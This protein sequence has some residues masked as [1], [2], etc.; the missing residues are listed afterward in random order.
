MA[1]ELILHRAVLAV[2]LLLPS[3]ADAAT[4]LDGATMGWP[5]ALPFAGI[6]LSIATGP[7]LFRKFWHAHYGKI[8]ALWALVALAALAVRFRHRD[9]T[10]RLGARPA[11]RIYELHHFAVR[12]LRGG[13]RH[14]D[15]RQFARRPAGKCRHS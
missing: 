3:A 13:R 4:A 1:M 11:R 9:L 10:H 14:I 12:A 2:A 15:H 8:A 6:L 7:L 5:W